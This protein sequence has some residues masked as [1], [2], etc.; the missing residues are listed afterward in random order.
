[1]P[2]FAELPVEVII[3]N[4]LPYLPVSAIASLSATSK[5]FYLITSDETFWK[6]KLLTDYNFS[7]NDT[8]RTTGWRFIY[9]RL[10]KPKVYV[11][12]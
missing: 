12:G 9:K 10:A 1:M 2:A 4:V 8:A 5:F 3:D 6:R 11:W 7:G